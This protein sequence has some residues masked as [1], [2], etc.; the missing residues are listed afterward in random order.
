MG[1]RT[2]TIGAGAGAI[3]GGLIW[4]AG[5]RQLSLGFLAGLGV[6]LALALL[7]W[8]LDRLRR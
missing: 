6:G 5:A 1:G 2:G 7:V 3:V 8:L 4:G